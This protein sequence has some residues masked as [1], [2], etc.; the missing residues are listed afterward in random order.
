MNI[1]KKVMFMF[2]A[3]GMVLGVFACR[4]NAEGGGEDPTPAPVVRT[5]VGLRASQS[6]IPI[7]KGDTGFS[8]SSIAIDKL[9]DSAGT[10]YSTVR[11]I[12]DGEDGWSVDV[13]SFDV[14]T[15]GTYNVKFTLVEDGKTFSV[16]V[17]IEVK[18]P[19]SISVVNIE[20]VNDPIKIDYEHNSGEPFDIRGLSVKLN[21]D[22]DSDGIADDEIYAYDFS[23]AAIWT[24]THSYD[25]SISGQY[26]V[27]VKYSGITE[28]VDFS[29]NVV[30]YISELVLTAPSR[31]EYIVTQQFEPAGLSAKLKYSNDKFVRIESDGSYIEVDEG[32]ATVITEFTSSPWRI[33]GGGVLTTVGK[34]VPINIE[35]SG[36][37]LRLY[38]GSG[39]LSPI[40][41][42]TNGVNIDVWNVKSISLK[43]PISD[44]DKVYFVGEPVKF[45]ED[46]FFVDSRMLNLTLEISGESD[47]VNEIAITDPSISHTHKIDGADSENKFQGT[48]AAV[49]VT[50]KFGE[51]ASDTLSFSVSV[52]EPYKF[53]ETITISSTKTVIDSDLTDFGGSD[54]SGSNAISYSCVEY[55]DYPQTIISNVN[56]PH[57]FEDA[58][59]EPRRVKRGETYM[60]L[61]TD[62][63]YYV[64]SKQKRS[65][66][67]SYSNGLSVPDNDSETW[68]RVEPIVWRVL[69]TNYDG[70]GGVL[71]WSDVGLD[72]VFYYSYGKEYTTGDVDNDIVELRREY[73]GKTIQYNNYK[74]STI[75]AFLLG[76]YESDD[77]NHYKYDEPG[78]YSK[79]E[80]NNNGF[81]QRA[82]SGLGDGIIKDVTVKNDITS[83][84]P[85]N[86][87]RNVSGPDG[88]NINSNL[89]NDVCENTVDKVFLLSSEELTRPSY[90][91]KDGS[92]V[93]S[94]STDWTGHVASSQGENIDKL[95]E[96]KLSDYALA[97]GAKLNSNLK[98]EYWIRSP[99]LKADAK[100]HVV[101]CVTMDGRLY[102][103]NSFTGRG[104]YR[105]NAVVPAICV[106]RAKLPTEVK[107]EW[108]L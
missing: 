92:R 42:I 15:P 17:T 26:P 107:K 51:Y 27:S 65:A 79:E 25:N 89:A 84:I 40:P 35:Y 18:E 59:T 105:A 28:T 90:Y 104:C 75:R 5:L 70:N 19:G 29:V 63:K 54:Y 82:F 50:Y 94:K 67:A 4:N 32:D 41:S 33:D 101:A 6:N 31:T 76:N 46:F 106:D 96:K 95:R 100:T 57:I 83:A 9:Y 39:N 85:T 66:S 49:T 56:I 69:D 91:F 38:D 87:T 93:V 61:G 62:G 45:F 2:I 71:L 77:V 98:G 30:P 13:G 11:D 68:F 64:K 74:Y 23:D 3:L 34:N 1:F 21:Y 58:T 47:K 55:G 44:K 24:V 80:Y 7:I 16:E 10:D 60:Y 103:E 20:K 99:M 86:G 53:H 43:D 37:K 88:S 102:G 73:G 14:N 12:K 52:V 81:L 97:R 8:V 78:D 36:K 48:S 72:R 22:T 108:G